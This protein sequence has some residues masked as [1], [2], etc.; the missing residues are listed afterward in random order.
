M[1]KDEILKS[2]KQREENCWTMAKT[3]LE[4]RD[5]HGLHDIGVER[6]CDYRKD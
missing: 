1:T 3:F 4:N 2:I 6:N 5:A